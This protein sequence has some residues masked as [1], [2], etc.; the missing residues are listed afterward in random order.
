[1]AAPLL[2]INDLRLEVRTV[3]GWAHLLQEVNLQLARGEVLGLVGETG[4]GKSVTALTIMR[5]F[6]MPPG[7]VSGGQVHFNGVDLLKLSEPEMRQIR[8][9]RIAMVFQDPMTF[10]N[11]VFT[12]GDQLVTALL[13]HSAPPGSARERRRWAQARAVELLRE[14]NIPAPRERLCQYPHQ[15]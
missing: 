5:L 9:R 8:G 12:I 2:E 10:L 11:P 3:D 6:P 4:C 1:M 13:A 7:R 15:F 14:V